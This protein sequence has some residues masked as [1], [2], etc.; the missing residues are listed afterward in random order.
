MGIRLQKS[1]M[2][3]NHKR[4]SV[5]LHYLVMCSGGYGVVVGSV[6]IVVGAV[7]V[8]LVFG[9]GKMNWLPLGINMVWTP[10]DSFKMYRYCRISGFC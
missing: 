8:V 4:L 5:I 2:T 10:G 7:L 3:V 6:G 1:K 9:N